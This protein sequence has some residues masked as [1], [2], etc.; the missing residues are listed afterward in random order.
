MWSHWRLPVNPKLARVSAA[1]TG[2]ADAVRV[3]S[4]RTHDATDEIQQMIETLQQT[5]R[6][7]V[8]GVETSRQLAGTSVE[9]AEAAN[10]RL[11]F[12]LRG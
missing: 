3:L 11:A 7:A 12:T 5:T 10:L 9:D 6:R 2:L 4:R 8:G 1:L